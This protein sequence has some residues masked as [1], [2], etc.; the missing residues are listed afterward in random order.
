LALGVVVVLLVLVSRARDS[1]PATVAI[2]AQPNVEA[3]TTA[4][5]FDAGA[6][7]GTARPTAVPPVHATAPT[8]TL[9]PPLTPTTAT[10]P[11][12]LGPFPRARAQLELDRAAA[13]VASCK[14]A[15]GPFGAGS[16]RIDF[17]P[18]GRVGTLSR[19]PFAGT[20][21]GACIAARFLSI[22]LGPFQGGTQEIKK[23]FVIQR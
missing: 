1:G 22:R 4:A 2:G 12:A 21:E 8:V 9:R 15:T 7:F 16:I 10:T 6:P 3:P 23:T 20:P 18:D 14:R 19:P 17:E 5:R 13:G 11:G